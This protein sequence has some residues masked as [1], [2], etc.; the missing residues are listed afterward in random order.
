MGGEREDIL[1]GVIGV[2]TVMATAAAAAAGE[3]EGGE[4][5]NE[6]ECGSSSC[7]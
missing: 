1:G 7:W 2:F 3:G 5:C 6:L 4:D